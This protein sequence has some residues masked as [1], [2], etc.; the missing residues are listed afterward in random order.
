MLSF[1]ARGRSFTGGG[2]EQCEASI[3][4]DESCDS[5]ETR[6]SRLSVWVSFT[7]KAWMTGLGRLGGGVLL[8]QKALPNSRSVLQLC[9]FFSISFFP[10]PPLLRRPYVPLTPLHL[11]DRRVQTEEESAS[12]LQ[13]WC[14]KALHFFKISREQSRF[15]GQLARAP[16]RL[17]D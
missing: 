14:K 15:R 13:V 9:L 6:F 8:W 1:V 10:P 16:G 5:L 4:R 11:C 7:L 3:R 17:A 12:S 2:G